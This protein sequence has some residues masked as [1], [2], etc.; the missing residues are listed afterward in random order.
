[1]KKRIFITGSTDGI[2]KL[3]AIKLAKE[4]H[5]IYLH[6][7]NQEKLSAVVSEI[8]TLSGNDNISGYLSDFSNLDVVRKMA[9]QIKQEIPQI[10]VLINNAGIFTSSIAQN[11]KGMDIRMV[12]NYLAP[13]VLSNALLPLLQKSDAARIINLSSAAQAPIDYEVLSNISKSIHSR[14]AA[15]FLTS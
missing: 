11:E 1:M 6:G 13:V 15:A 9:N 8:K 12:V 14:G 2:G 7:R 10:D 4:G 5:E 3:A